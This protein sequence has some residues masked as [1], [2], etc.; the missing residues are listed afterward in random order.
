MIVNFDGRSDSISGEAPKTPV[1]WTGKFQVTDFEGNTIEETWER[2][3]APPMHY[4]GARKRAAQLIDNL[5]ARLFEQH[6]MKIKTTCFTL[7][8]R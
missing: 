5:T 2:N 3:S 1:K 8:S 4:Q 7:Q 6:K